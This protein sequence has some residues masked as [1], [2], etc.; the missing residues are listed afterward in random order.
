[1]LEIIYSRCGIRE[2]TLVCFQEYSV[3]RLDPALI[4]KALTAYKATLAFR[5]DG[6]A[7]RLADA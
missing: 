5:F 4:A 7:D 2:I 1:M 6:G 3:C